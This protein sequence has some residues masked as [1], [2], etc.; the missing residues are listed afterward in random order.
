M[1]FFSYIQRVLKKTFLFLIVLYLGEVL[2]A[3][4]SSSIATDLTV[5]RNF[6]PDQKFWSIGQTVRG[7]FHFSPH[8]TI[9]AALVYYSP[10]KFHNYFIATAKSPQTVPSEVAY[11]V[12]GKWRMREISIGWKHYFKGSFDQDRQWN[13]YG[14]VGFGLVF[15]NVV[16]AFA[17]VDTALYN[18][19]PAP[20]LGE[21]EFKRLT[22]DL[23]IGGEIP[24]GGNFYAYAE[25]KTMLPTTDYA[26]PYLHNNK[27]VPLPAI[28]NIGL[29]VLFGSW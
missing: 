5:L 18:S 3:Q 14:I 11:Y 10:G 29:R 7:D 16:N 22:L 6:S 23:G 4:P 13:F 2:H 25:A 26:S 27:N 12:A 1:V 17:P 8:E 9:Y 21:G 19:P 28:V 15:S 24:L 20:V